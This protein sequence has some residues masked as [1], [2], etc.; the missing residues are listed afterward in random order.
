MGNASHRTFEIVCEVDS[1]V[2]PDLTAVRQQMALLA[3]VSDAL[4]VP[5]NHR[6][7]ATVSSVAV[8]SE[9]VRLGARAIACLNARDRNLL[10]LRRDVITA[11]AYNV[12]ELLFVYGDAPSLGDRSTT[13]VRQMLREVRGMGIALRVGV[14]ADITKPLPDWK[15]DA[16]FVCTQISLGQTAVSRWRQRSGF[17]GR[18]YAGVVVL[19][20]RAMAGRLMDLI[21]GL[22]VPEATLRLLDRDPEAGVKLAVEQLHRLRHGGDVDGAHLVP[23]RRHRELAEALSRSDLLPSTAIHRRTPVAVA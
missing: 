7:H 14:S 16:D 9:A 18:V 13:T 17:D 15:R 10:G 12:D 22:D 11:A 2:T 5:D 4:L 19:S 1:P 23:A 6:G 21:P 20:S 8:A 3:T